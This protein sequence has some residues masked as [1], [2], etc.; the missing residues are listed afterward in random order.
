[1]EALAQGCQL[2]GQKCG[3]EGVEDI[4]L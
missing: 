4:V 3:M 1:M 2:A